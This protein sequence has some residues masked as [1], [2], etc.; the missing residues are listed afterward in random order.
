MR[1][2]LGV[3]WTTEWG[4]FRS[5]VGVHIVTVDKRSRSENTKY[6]D[7]FLRNKTKLF[8]KCVIFDDVIKL[9]RRTLFCQWTVMTSK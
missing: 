3:V 8:E 9:N 5:L 1:L 6:D 4:I 7:C 2:R